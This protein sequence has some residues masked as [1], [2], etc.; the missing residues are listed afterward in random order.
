MRRRDES[1]LQS[2]LP[3]IIH[4]PTLSFAHP[5]LV[6]DF[7]WWTASRGEYVMSGSIG[8]HT[9]SPAIPRP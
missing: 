7:A 6:K 1:L 8:I 5:A 9:E 2:A 4:D 3:P